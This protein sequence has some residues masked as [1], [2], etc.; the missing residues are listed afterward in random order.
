MKLKTVLSNKKAIFFFVFPGFVLYTVF[1]VLPVVWSGYYTFFDGIPGIKWEFCGFDNFVRLFHDKNFV[2]ALIVNLKYIGIVTAGQVCIGLLLALMFKYWL[3]HFATLVRTI[4][5]FPVVLPTV[6]V[7]QLFAKIYEIQP[8]YGL[9]N[10]L[11]K[12]VGLQDLVQPWIGQAST[13]LGSLS[14]MDIWTAVGFYAIIF[15]G[16]LLDIPEDVVEAA[17]IDGCRPLQLFRMVLAPLLRPMIITCVIFSFTGTVKMFESAL[18]L[19]GGGP[20]G[21]TKSLSIYM[22]D[23]AFTYSKTGYG[24]VIALFIFLVCVVGSRIIRSFEKP[25]D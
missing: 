16:A 7:G 19:T 14:A 13:A 22:Y 12:A 3:K 1:V 5:F 8:H 24:S 9:L 2:K 23:T 18:A 25:I 10:S 4:V 15:Y 21:A 17:R 20:G 6:A 11:L